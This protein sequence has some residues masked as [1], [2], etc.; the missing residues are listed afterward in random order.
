MPISTPS[1]REEAR[2][3]AMW[4]SSTAPSNAHTPRPFMSSVASSWRRQST[5]P[6]CSA[7]APYRSSVH[8]DSSLGASTHAGRQDSD[9]S[10]SQ[11]LPIPPAP[12]RVK[13][14]PRRWT[15]RRHP[16]R[17]AY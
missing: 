1:G 3:A 4:D 12:A 16:Q 8:P 9:A 14:H 17:S 5:E 10:T 7:A 11:A 13:F 6:L 15:A 2:S